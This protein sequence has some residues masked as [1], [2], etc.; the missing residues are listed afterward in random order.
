MIYLDFTIYSIVFS[1]NLNYW[2]E[3]QLE[4]KLLRIYEFVEIDYLF[5][6]VWQYLW[7][8]WIFS[9]FIL[10]ISWMHNLT[11]LIIFWCQNK[12]KNVNLSKHFDRP[13]IRIHVWFTSTT[14]YLNRHDTHS[15]VVIKFLRTSQIK[16]LFP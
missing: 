15:H 13:Q 4:I 2:L 3:K 5:C 10:P 9:V 12:F 8:H 14:F 16:T 1:Y 7:W 6:V 11:H